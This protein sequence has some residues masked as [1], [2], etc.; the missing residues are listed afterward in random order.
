MSRGLLAGFPTMVIHCQSQPELLE[1]SVQF[2][3]EFSTAPAFALLPSLT[4]LFSFKL[5]FEKMSQESHNLRMI[6]IMPLIYLL[7]T[8]VRE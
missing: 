5:K 2:L 8:E 3:W 7:L 1:I 6:S 4:C